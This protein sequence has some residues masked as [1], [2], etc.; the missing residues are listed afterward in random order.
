MI[1]LVDWSGSMSNC[2]DDTL[3]QVISLALFC[4]RAM[5]PYQVFAFTSE[6][7]KIHRNFPKRGN[8]EFKNDEGFYAT[9]SVNLLELFSSKM[10]QSEFNRMVSFML[11]NPYT[12]SEHYS[13]GGTHLNES[14]LYL[15]HKHIS[16]FL[17]THNVEKFSFITLTDGQGGALYSPSGSV[18]ESTYSYDTHKSY[19]IKN[20]LRD[21][22]TKK[23]Y[24]LDR[25][26]HTNVL[27]NVIRDRFNATVV[28]FH[29]TRNSRRDITQFC[30][31]NLREVVT[32]AES[33][34][35]SIM[36]DDLRVELRQNGFATIKGSGHE[37]MFL[38]SQTKLSI[39]D[40]SD[41]E[42]KSD[43]NSRVIARQFEKFMNTKKTSRVLLNRFVN[44]IA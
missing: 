44:L 12:M 21:P 30:K 37:E 6:Y 33:I 3:E 15:A 13:L 29:I 43:M 19:K 40:E 1:M 20:Y 31:D 26:N 11:D 38:I 4:Q 17:R 28:G 42:V 14:L 36:I 16:S 18:S 35:R 32:S 5:I 34:N 25:F 24:F 23:E 2:I 39:N 22:I 41:L 9:H 10:T 7:D 27:L 8:V